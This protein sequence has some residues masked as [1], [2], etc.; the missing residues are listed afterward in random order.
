MR[1][2]FIL[3]LLLIHQLGYGQRSGRRPNL[4]QI[5][6]AEKI[7]LSPRCVG[8]S[9]KIRVEISTNS[10]KNIKLFGFFMT[11]TNY[12]LFAV[13]AR[14]TKAVTL[15]INKNLAAEIR[16]RFMMDNVGMTD[17]AVKFSSDQSNYLG[18]EMK[19]EIGAD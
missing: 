4:P 11:Q 5:F 2:L 8:D 17:Q 7:V 15:V 1:S 14:L 3:L 16:I 12:E 6:Y 10:E 18:N 19:L 9:I 13:G